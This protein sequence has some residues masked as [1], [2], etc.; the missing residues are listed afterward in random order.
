MK[1][2]RW[3]LSGAAG[4]VVLAGMAAGAAEA[5]LSVD[6]LS[7]YV[8]RGQVLNDDAS[9]QPSLTVDA[10]HGFSLNV[11]GSM[12]RFRDW[13]GII[14]NRSRGVPPDGAYISGSGSLSVSGSTPTRHL[15]FRWP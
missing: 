11:W 10:G 12:R 15:P 5:E 14:E 2:R 6:A 13:R 9:L 7:R 1:T 3:V 8:W 4:L